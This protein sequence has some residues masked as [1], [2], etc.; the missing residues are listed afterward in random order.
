VEELLLLASGKGHRQLCA[1]AILKAMHI[2][3]HLDGRE[4]LFSVPMSDQDVFHLVEEKVYRSSAACSR[5]AFRSSSSWGAAKNKDSLYTKLLSKS[6]SS[7]SQI[8]DKLRFRIVTRTPTTSSPCSSTCRSS[9]C[10]STTWCPTR[11]STRSSTS[12]ATASTSRT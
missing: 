3:H 6:D 12:G 2:I 8:Y 4:L 9:S 10:R 5:R 1:C 11:A 7:A